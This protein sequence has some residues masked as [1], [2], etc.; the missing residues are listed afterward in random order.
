[1]QDEVDLSKL[2]TGPK[3]TT[4]EINKGNKLIGST[5]STVTLNLIKTFK[6]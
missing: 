2:Y 3:K 4:P 1:M 6:N 5:E